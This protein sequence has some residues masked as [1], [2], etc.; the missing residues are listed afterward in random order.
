[1]ATA[2]TA[3]A[4]VSAV[5]AQGEES[6]ASTAPAPA[7]AATATPA[8]DNHDTASTAGSNLILPLRNK[9]C[10]FVLLAEFDI[11]RGST[12]AHQ[13][14]ATIGH[15]DHILAELM[16]PDGAH[17][18]SED[19]TVFFLKQTSPRARQKSVT[20][21][22][23]TGADA[24]NGRSSDDTAA[25]EDGE[26]GKAKAVGS[27]PG[28]GGSSSSAD[29]D[30]VYV[31]NLVRTKHDNTIFK[32]VLLLALDDYF[33]N[34]GIDCL[35]RL[36]EAINNMDLTGMPSFSVPEKLILRASERRDLFEERFVAAGRKDEKELSTATKDTHFFD[37]SITFRQL[38]IPI[39]LPLTTF[40]EEVGE[41]SLL[42]FMQTFANS[43]PVGPQHPHLHS[44]GALTH[45]IVLLFNA[46]ATQ[47]RVIFLGHGQPANDVATFVLAACALGSGCGSVF[48]GFTARAFPYA[49]LTSLDEMEKVPGYIAGVTNPRFEDLPAWDVICNIETGKITVSKDIEPAPPYGT[50]TA[51]SHAHSRQGLARDHFSSGSLSYAS[52][53]F[54]NIQAL[55][56]AGAGSNTGTVS[57]IPAG[58]MIKE[59]GGQTT[60][61]SGSSSRAPSEVDAQ[62]ISGGYSAASVGGGGGMG[63]LSRTGTTLSSGKEKAIHIE[64]RPD[65]LDNVLI[66]DLI[67][68]IQSRYGEAYVRARMV[69]YASL[70]GRIVSRHEE[71]FWGHTKIGWPSQP[72]LNGQLGSGLVYADREMEM[73]EISVNAMRA[74]GWRASSAYPLFRQDA[75]HREVTREIRS[76]DVLHQIQRLRR[77][78]QLSHGESDLI[79]SAIARAVRTPEQI[80]EL[81]SYLPAHNGGLN[82]LA[83]GLYHPVPTVRNGMVDFFANLCSHPVARKFVGQ[84]STFHRLALARLLHEREAAQVHAQTMRLAQAQ[85]QG[86]P[87]GMLPGPPGGGLATMRLRAESSAPIPAAL[88][89]PPLSAPPSAPPP[90]VPTSASTANGSANASA[91][92]GT[93]VHEPHTQSPPPPPPAPPMP[94]FGAV[95]EGV[96]MEARG[97]AGT[98]GS[99]P[100]QSQ[101]RVSNAASVAS[102]GAAAQAQAS[103][104]AAAGGMASPPLPTSAPPPIPIAIPVSAS[105]PAQASSASSPPRAAPP[106]PP[107]P[108]PHQ[109]P[110]PV[111]VSTRLALRNR[112]NS[113]V[114][115]QGSAGS[116]GE[117]A[118]TVSAAAAAAAAA[119]AAAGGGGQVPPLP[120]MSLQQQ[121]QQQ[122]LGVPGGG[123]SPGGSASVAGSPAL[124]RTTTTTST[125]SAA[126]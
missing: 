93:A 113:S 79:Y 15:D 17:A 36:Y 37:T 102:L 45:P 34:P 50:P 49:N 48:R 126:A 6:P 54:G 114:S 2:T 104:A 105:T 75:I 7:P 20:G 125:S 78:K 94:P 23:S 59:E 67:S 43:T 39:R 72:F 116:R 86:G 14:P 40:P 122:Q 68:A 107:P 124:S 25:G 90:P 80:V 119:N 84:L 61:T 29:S 44:N 60:S 101:R 30:I 53:S 18:R 22:D 38:S 82:P 70:F 109:H 24:A 55:Q 4:A 27:R 97:S 106:P 69:D 56:A 115:T 96:K 91:G 51:H 74:E 108:P 77:A 117:G 26:I 63:T 100:A 98:Q 13:Y 118:T 112:A 47:K 111:G 120:R 92:A 88:S 12:L 31:L 62:S 46:M 123:S 85:G 57:S 65:A 32:P 110:H 73:R 66:E 19:W 99:S 8:A 16:L 89:S 9:H 42:K 21:K 5:P 95:V 1:M 103:A 58:A 71:H 64:G 52:G 83:Y 11:D 3:A 76:F 81:L 121:Q 28:T 35:A 10:H 87:N 41:Y 33:A